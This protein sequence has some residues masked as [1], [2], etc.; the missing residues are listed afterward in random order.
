VTKR[1]AAKQKQTSKPVAP[2]SE[3]R[4]FAWAPVEGAVAYRVELFRGTKQ[5]LRARTKDP[6]YELVSPW[7]HLG[8][9]ENL[10]AGSYRWYV[11]PIFA[12]GPAAEAVVQAK[13][14]IP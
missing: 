11:W 8:R 9:T 14:S 2:A 4:R 10:T 12:S 3:Q 1:Q 6:V 13:L 7:R 5:V